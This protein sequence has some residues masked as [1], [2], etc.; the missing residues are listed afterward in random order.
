V[1]GN[2]QCGGHAPLPRSFYGR[3]VHEVARD[4]LG[5]LVVRTLAGPRGAP[6]RLAGRIVEVEAYDG[7]ADLA[8]HASK[9]RTPRTEVMFGE[10]GHAY[11]YLVYGMH[12]CLNVVT[13]PVDYAAAV[14]IRALEAVE[15][16]EDM[17]SGRVPPARIASGPGRLTRALAIDRSHNRADLCAPGALFIEAGETVRDRDV[18][19]GPR[20]GVDYAG[21]WARRPW[22]LGVRGSPALSRPFGARARARRPRPRTG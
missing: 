16:L 4:L 10:A 7:P 14:L 1:V 15:G 3:T 5:M 9:G 22:R 20:I 19:R 18:V 12:C 21:P 8:C 13:G 2:R 6:S 17:R 11:V